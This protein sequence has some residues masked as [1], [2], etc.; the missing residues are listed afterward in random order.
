MNKKCLSL[1][2]NFISSFFSIINSEIMQAF[3]IKVLCIL[4]II[5]ILS[6]NNCALLIRN[7]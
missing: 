5:N 6:I 3:G 1:S 4:S 7:E 2:C